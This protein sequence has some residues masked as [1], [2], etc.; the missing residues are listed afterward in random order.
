MNG[1]SVSFYSAKATFCGR[2][3]PA[4]ATV[5]SQRQ[6]QRPV[7]VEGQRPG[8]RLGFGRIVVLET[9]VLITLV[10]LVQSG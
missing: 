1:Y 10:S 7:V 9:E 5:A 3:A 4:Q 2:S 8:P 6:R